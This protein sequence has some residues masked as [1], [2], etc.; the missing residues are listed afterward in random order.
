MNTINQ[1]LSDAQFYT[2]NAEALFKPEVDVLLKGLEDALR[3][4]D[5]VDL[6]DMGLI[7]YNA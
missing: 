4:L 5:Y 6:P 3:C 2:D 1:S 7:F